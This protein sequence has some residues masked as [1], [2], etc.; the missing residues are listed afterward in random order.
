MEKNLRPADLSDIGLKKFAP[1]IACFIAVFTLVVLPGESLPTEHEWMAIAFVDKW[2]HTFMFALLTFLFL[3]PVG[4]SSLFKQQ[5]RHY[6]TRI[7]LSA[8]IWGLTTEYIQG[9]Y[10]PTRSFD[11]FDWAADSLGVLIAFIYCRRFHNR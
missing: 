4:H 10:I 11:L 9:F 7:C 8:C 5:K 2:V 6:F 1:A 3:L